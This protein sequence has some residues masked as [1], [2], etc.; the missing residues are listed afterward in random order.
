MSLL[1]VTKTSKILTCKYTP[2]YLCFIVLFQILS[3]FAFEK[4]QIIE[5][6]SL[7][8]FELKFSTVKKANLMVGQHLIG[9]VSYKPGETIASVKGYRKFYQSE[10]F[11][12]FKNIEKRK[13]ILKSICQP[14]KLKYWVT[15]VLQSGH[16]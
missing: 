13:A 5:L 4:S 10:I 3:A 2:F 1:L 15:P 16:F 7:G 6:S 9:K 14:A 12:F 8:T 11:L